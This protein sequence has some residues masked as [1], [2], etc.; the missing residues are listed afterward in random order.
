MSILLGGA[1]CGIAALFFGSMF[2]PIKRYNA[3]DGALSP[4]SLTIPWLQEYSS[5]G[6]WATLSSALASSSMPTRSFPPSTRWP[7]W[8]ACYG[9]S[10]MPQP[11]PSFAG[12]AWPWAS[13]SGT[14]PTVYVLPFSSL[15]FFVSDNGMGMWNFWT[16]SHRELPCSARRSESLGPPPAC[17]CPAQLSRARLCHPR[18]SILPLPRLN[19]ACS[20]II[21]SQVRSGPSNKAEKG[22]EAEKVA[23]NSPSSRTEEEKEDVEEEAA[24]WGGR[25]L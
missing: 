18:V 22:T 23:L 13:S 9:P 16:I 6:L 19:T 25:P 14:R 20:G 15:Y 5:N 3:G 10:E 12:L 17:Q 21:F 7:C 8:G 1:A 4:V 24:P 11:S 2:V